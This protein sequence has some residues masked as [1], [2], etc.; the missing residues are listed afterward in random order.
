MT[1]ETAAPDK[2][3]QT[4]KAEV[5]AD[6]AAEP[7]VETD[8]APEPATP[9]Q[10]V[11]YVT[12]PQPPRNKGNRG[13]GALFALLSGIV[14][15]GL[16]A[17]ATALMAMVNGG[18]LD[19]GFLRDARFYI[20]VL[21]FVIGFVLLVLILNRASW[22]AYIVGSLLVAVFV[23]FGTIA[24]GLLG[25]GIIQNTPSQALARYGE[26]LRDPFIILSALLAREVS[27]WA[28]AAIASRG[29]RVK[30]RNVESRATFDRELAETRAE[31]ESAPAA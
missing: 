6:A 7:A 27:I 14:F 3:S 28:G 25:S 21:F 20:P 22:S 8:A 11:V 2:K 30:A 5:P 15:V 23:Y 12:E 24:L 10:Q 31:R 19:F 29:R 13:V 1:D 9:A 16:L 4:S 18:A 26:A 17:V